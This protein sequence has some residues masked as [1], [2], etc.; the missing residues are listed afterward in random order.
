VALNTWLCVPPR[1]SVDEIVILIVPGLPDLTVH[2]AVNFVA[3]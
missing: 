2:F 3:E 1:V